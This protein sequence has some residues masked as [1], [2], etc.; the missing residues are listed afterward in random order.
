MV[1]EELHQRGAE[2]LGPDIN[3][4]QIAVVTVADQPSGKH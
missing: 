4:V 2:M 3:A 1:K